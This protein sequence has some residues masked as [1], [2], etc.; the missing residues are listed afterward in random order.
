M[1]REK[2]IISTEE[3]KQELIH[4]DSVSV[5]RGQELLQD[6]FTYKYSSRPEI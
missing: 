5:D 2:H 3:S 4:I 1:K 6:Y